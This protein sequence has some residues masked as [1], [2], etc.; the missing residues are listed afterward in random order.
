MP[1][2]HWIPRAAPAGPRP[3]IP[4]SSGAG[5]KGSEPPGPAAAPLATA[6]LRRY[7]RHRRDLPWRQDADPYRIWVSEV[8]L[9]QTRVETVLPYYARW[10]KRFPTV[11][12]LADA[13]LDDVLK[14]WEGL[15]YYA[16]ARN[17]HRA[18]R[19]VQE[20]HGGS[21]PDDPEA[22][23]AL[24]G[25]GEYTTGA[26]ASIA[27]G[28]RLPAVDGNVRRVLSRL[29]DLPAPTAAE[30]RETAAALVPADRPGDF[31]QA[32][33]ELGAT[34]CTPRSP[35]CAECPVAEFCLAL[36]RGTVAERPGRK[37]VGALPLEIVGTAVVRDAAG[38]L[39]LVR[40]PATGLLGGL[41]EFP[42]AVVGPDEAP[43]AAA[44]RAALAAGAV[45]A[46]DAAATAIGVVEHTFSH[47]RVA[48]RAFA[49]RGA[50]AAAADAAEPSGAG[51]APG[52]PVQGGGRHPATGR[53][54]AD[55]T[56][57]A[58]L[59]LPVAQRKLAR[60][61]AAARPRL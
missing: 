58:E 8:M 33:M 31:N 38:R 23:R 51:V 11:A 32:L 26:V 18:A 22:L 40:R 56:A 44:R 13:P 29:Y 45:L 24:P 19:L 61:A 35:R 53:T 16:R 20:R 21:L 41:W 55:E 14:S 25:F 3:T 4:R 47:K 17:L 1:S 39:L 36:A 5:R 12:A 27:Y 52:D 60:L 57:L 48:Y 10:L 54:W 30:L 6:L 50:G 34:I 9:Q 2:G 15:G 7:D 49:F 37:R 43:E 59:A 42:G 46:P 28:R